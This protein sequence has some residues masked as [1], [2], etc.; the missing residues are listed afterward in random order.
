MYGFPFKKF[1][2]LTVLVDLHANQGQL[3]KHVMYYLISNKFCLK[4]FSKLLFPM[5]LNG[6]YKWSKHSICV[7]ACVQVCVNKEKERERERESE[8][9]KINRI[10]LYSKRVKLI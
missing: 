4:Y 9:V 10:P 1:S 6:V 2:I 7:R 8:N 3:H 5:F